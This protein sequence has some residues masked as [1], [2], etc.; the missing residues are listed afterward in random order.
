[1]QVVS[2]G[3]NLHAI[4]KYDRRQFAWNVK[5]YFLGITISKC[6]LLKFLSSVLSISFNCAIYF[7]CF[8]LL[9]YDKFDFHYENTP[10]H[11]NFTTQN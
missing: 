6:R 3:E 5:D 8:I 1:M 7:K 2:N 9:I 11:E 4:S 10:I